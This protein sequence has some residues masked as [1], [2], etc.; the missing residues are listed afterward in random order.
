[1]IVEFKANQ[2]NQ[3]IDFVLGIQNGEFGLG[4][5]KDEQQDLMDTAKFYNGGG[6]WIA[7]INAEIVG[8]IGLQKLNSECGILRKMFVKKELRGN[9]L[10]IAQHLFEHLL[11]NARKLGFKNI[12]LDT[13]SVAK[14]SHRFYQKNGF[15]E[16]S[17]ERIPEGYSF[18]DRN[19]K[20]FQLKLSEIKT[21]FENQKLKSSKNN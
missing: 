5:K 20:I 11:D 2:Q 12:Y 19:S 9:E 3:L 13:P 10:K 17:Q 16:L 7:Q 14:A 4:F 8:C 1:M 21:T 15:V 6:F 18:P